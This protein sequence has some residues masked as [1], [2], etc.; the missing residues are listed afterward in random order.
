M[1][2]NVPFQGTLSRPPAPGRIRFLVYFPFPL[3][4][5]GLR[6][7]NCPAWRKPWTLCLVRH[8]LEEQLCRSPNFS[9]C[10]SCQPSCGSFPYSPFQGCPSVAFSTYIPFSAE[11]FCHWW[12][13]VPSDCCKRGSEGKRR[14]VSFSLDRRGRHTFFPYVPPFGVS[15]ILLTWPF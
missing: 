9:L 10:C 7:V 6:W 1:T 4:S 5:T 11:S 3:P 2:E 14:N 13:S 12:P 15:A 8:F